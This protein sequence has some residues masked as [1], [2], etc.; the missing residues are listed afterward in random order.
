[1]SDMNQFDDE[2]LFDLNNDPID[3]N[4]DVNPF[5]DF[6]DFKQEDPVERLERKASEARYGNS[7]PDNSLLNYVKEKIGSDYIMSGSDEDPIQIPLVDLNNKQL[8]DLLKYN[9]S[10]NTTT[11]EEDS[12]LDDFEVE[13]LNA[14][15][16]GNIDRVNQ[17]LGN[18]DY[19]Q[20]YSDDDVLYWKLSNLY[21]DLDE[22]QLG[23]E[24]EI[25]KESPNFEYK[26]EQARKELSSVLQR[27]KEEELQEIESL[28]SSKIREEYQVVDELID[29]ISHIHNFIV[30]DDIKN[31]VRQLIF[32]DTGKS[33]LINL[34]DTREGLLEIATAY[35]ILPKIAGYVNRLTDEIAELKKK[36]VVVD[37]KNNYNSKQNN[38]YNSR[39]E[40]EVEDVSD[41]FFGV[42]I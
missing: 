37:N 33:E 17:L 21:P 7:G 16:S 41:F 19:S 5:F 8:L 40:D 38:R 25:M 35:A 34:L 6:D 31:N 11:D 10:T 12:D 36:R 27:Q 4:N 14:Y 9:E 22:T 3:V 39:L 1:M 26:L 15:R 2:I 28:K 42:D 18:S 32:S 20:E 13:L 24:L 29:N 23:I 30:D